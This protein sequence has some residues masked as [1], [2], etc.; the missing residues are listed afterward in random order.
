MAVP[1][2]PRVWW[3]RYRIAGKQYSLVLQR[4]VLCP[5]WPGNVAF[6]CALHWR[7]ASFVLTLVRWPISSFKIL[8]LG[9]GAE[10]QK[11]WWVREGRM[12]SV[13]LE[14]RD[15]K[16]G[17]V[18]FYHRRFAVL[19]WYE[20]E[21]ECVCVC[22]DGIN[23]KY[24]LRWHIHLH[25]FILCYASAVHKHTFFCS[26]AWD[27][28]EGGCVGVFSLWLSVLVST[29]V[30]STF[31]PIGSPSS[32]GMRMCVCVCKLAEYRMNWYIPT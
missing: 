14:F 30:I 1:H 9:E 20:R 22:V 10:K 29:W 11:G 2:R 24:A 21:G 16:D 3:N 5:R 32:N 7:R 25:Q 6:C 23:L 31:I 17:N 18:H 12:L 15:W 28:R 19:R 13:C 8:L 4:F 26:R 27:E